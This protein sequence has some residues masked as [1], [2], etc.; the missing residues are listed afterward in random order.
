M[1]L[2][3]VTDLL[4]NFGLDAGLYGT[5]VVLGLLLRYCRASWV[6]FDD[7]HTLAA[8]V[9]FGLVGAALVLTLEHR[10]WQTV[11]LQGLTLGVAVLIVERT[12]RAM[13]GKIP[14]LPA[15]NAWV[16]PGETKEG[17]P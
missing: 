10:A 6:F 17:T 9:A 14:A 4:K 3:A 13:G 11:V 2:T 8:G 12:L 7:P 16:R 15:D 1:D 5:A